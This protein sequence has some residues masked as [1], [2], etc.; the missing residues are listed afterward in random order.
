M[1]RICLP[2]EAAFCLAYFVLACV[3]ALAI[4][5]VWLAFNDHPILA[6]VFATTFGIA[7]WKIA[8]HSDSRHAAM[9]RLRSIRAGRR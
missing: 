9:A 7:Y 5:S 8:N 3:L 6:I 1:K 2:D 4:L